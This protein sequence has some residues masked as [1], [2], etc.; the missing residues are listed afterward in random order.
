MEPTLLVLMQII[1]LAAVAALCIYLIV[2]LAR[3]RAILVAM[4]KDIKELSAKAI[5]VIENLEVIT[6]R[7]KTITENIDEQVDVVKH[8]VTALKGV[9]D[10]IV[11]FERRVQ[12]RI[13]EPV[14]DTVTT[15]AALLKGV[16]TFVTRLR[17]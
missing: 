11:E 2:V 3:V 16:R 15:F 10:N 1:A 8:A 4:E 12:E 17:A 14:L 7:V 9:A 5:P 6:D 13:E